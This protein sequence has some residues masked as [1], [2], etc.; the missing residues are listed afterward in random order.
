M[1]KKRKTSELTQ[2]TA[3]FSLPSSPAVPANLLLSD[4]D[5][6]FDH[7]LA[8]TNEYQGYFVESDNDVEVEYEE[9][10][11]EIEDSSCSRNVSFIIG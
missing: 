8:G 9:E 1:S 2:E 3:S 6:D 5:D 7:I 11:E 10:N 4:D